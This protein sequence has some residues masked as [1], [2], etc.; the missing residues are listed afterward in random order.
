MDE[1]GFDL[2]QQ[3]GRIV[4]GQTG[5]NRFF[6]KTRQTGFKSLRLR[7]NCLVQVDITTP[8]HG[9]ESPMAG[10]VFTIGMQVTN[11]VLRV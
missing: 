8:M 2:V 3:I 9:I 5:F 10:S 7:I 11:K 6:G 1:S 4:N